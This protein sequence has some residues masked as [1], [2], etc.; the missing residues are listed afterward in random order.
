MIHVNTF[1]PAHN[2]ERYP[3]LIL[4]P[5]FNDWDAV[6]LLLQK[7]DA[8]MGRHGLEPDVLLVDDASAVP[9]PPEVRAMRFRA[10]RSVS[11][12]A[13]RRNLGHQRAIAIGLA[14]AEERLACRAVVVMD[15]D[16]EDAPE[17]VPRLLEKLLES[18]ETQVV[19]AE[20]T[21]R[22]EDWRF[23]LG[24]QV[25]K[26]LHY[27]LTG[28]RVRVGNFSIIPRSLLRRLVVVAEMW[29]HYAAA[30]FK[31]RIPHTTIPTR[32][33]PRLMGRSHMNFVGLVVHGLSAL[34]VY[35]EVIGVRLLLVNGLMFVLAGLLLATVVA[36][37]LATNLAIP[38]W[39]SI[40]GGIL[41]LLLLQLLCAS[42]PFIFIILHGRGSASFLPAR[43]YALFIDEVIPMWGSHR[44]Q[45]PTPALS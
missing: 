31:A 10:I 18:G 21:R 33:A 22:S 32:R 7:V 20:R 3:L 26:C 23:R 5:V 41:L 9:C 44:H 1:P 25:Y 19:F 37:R 11:T 17:D 14:Y 24:Y 29:N 13:L 6:R 35:S 8:E 4:I 12:L 38:G 28:V 16:G 27:L 40:L 42:A 34:S 2:E 45:E 39:A 36:I 43:D 30:V 15:G